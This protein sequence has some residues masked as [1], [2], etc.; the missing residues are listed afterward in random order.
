MSFGLYLGLFFE[1]PQDFNDCLF[2]FR[3]NIGCR[4]AVFA[5]MLV[6]VLPNLQAIFPFYLCGIQAGNLEPIVIKNVLLDNRIGCFDLPCCF[7]QFFHINLHLN[8][9]IGEF[10]QKDNRLYMCTPW[11]QICC[12]GILYTVAPLF[13]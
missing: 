12:H 9:S 7:F 1:M 6:I 3:R 2:L 11:E 13:Q 10:G 8:R 5:P 4:A